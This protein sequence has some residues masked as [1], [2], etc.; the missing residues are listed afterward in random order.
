[1]MTLTLQSCMNAVTTGAQAAYGR[2]NLKSSLNDQYI[3][4]QIDHALHWHSDRFKDSSISVYTFNGVVLLT[5]E[6]PNFILKTE[7]GYIAKH[8]SGVNEIYNLLAV[9]M[10]ASSLTRIS[11]TWI[12]TKIKAR[13]IAE[14]D[15]D[16]SQIKV[17]TENGTVYLMGILPPDQAQLA[18][19]IARNIDGVQN[20]VKVFSYIHINKKLT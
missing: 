12:T 1:M 20:V 11:D 16:P 13:L 6:T 3:T 10:P 18:T 9:G 8:V 7:A 5:G 4:M 14:N 15:L 19:E 17:I 2:H